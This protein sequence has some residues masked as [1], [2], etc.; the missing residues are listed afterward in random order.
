MDIN[1]LRKE[2][3]CN[4][5]TAKQIAGKYNLTEVQIKGLL[6]RNGIKRGL[7]DKF[8]GQKEPH[9][10]EFLI[11]Q[12]IN[13]N[14]TH[15]QIMAE[16]NLSSSKVI[17]SLRKYGIKKPLELRRK[18]VD[19][20]LVTKKA[21]EKMYFQE[22]L[23]IVQIG[24]RLGVDYGIVI[25]YFKRLG[26]PRSKEARYAR[27]RRQDELR[28]IRKICKRNTK[29]IE[30]C[31][32]RVR[33]I[34]HGKPMS[35]Q[36]K[37]KSGLAQVINASL[38]SKRTLPELRLASILKD[39]NISF[40]EQCPVAIYDMDNGKLMAT[41]CLDFYI[42][43]YKFLEVPIVI[44]VD[45]RYA[46]SFKNH[47]SRDEFQ[48][49]LLADGNYLTIKLPRKKIQFEELNQP[50]ENIKEFLATRFYTSDHLI[51][52]LRD[53]EVTKENV[54]ILL[55]K[56]EKAPMPILLHFKKESSDTLKQFEAKDIE[57]LNP[58]LHVPFHESL[59]ITGDDSG[60]DIK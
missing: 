11:E 58:F 7:P 34:R 36:S 33:K 53:N 50:I 16:F 9:T 15:R 10:K 40:E 29:K 30:K 57:M 21:L 56:A 25:A 54:E 52:R 17:K 23:S 60:E 1:T 37:L 31:M 4:N 28:S 26:I 46:H 41:F 27:V 42:S 39:L 43:Q 12:F 14:K 59:W 13:L 19:L 3:L 47:K 44:H 5:L 51:I 45:G 48:D 6:H 2:Y 35:S 55:A 20:H 49:S 8:T 22:E 24:E 38:N 18:K 32:K